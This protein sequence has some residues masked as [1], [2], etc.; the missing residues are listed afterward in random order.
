[1]YLD[2]HY[3]RTYSLPRQSKAQPQPV[4]KERIKIQPLVLTSSLPTPPSSPRRSPSKAKPLDLESLSLNLLHLIHSSTS[5]LTDIAALIHPECQIE[6]EFSFRDNLHF[7]N[8][9]DDFLVHLTQR[10]TDLARMKL[11]VRESAVDEGQKKVWVVADVSDG[12][13]QTKT[14]KEKVVMMTFDAE[15]KLTK[16]VAFI[17]RVSTRGED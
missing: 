4:L 7:Y 6:H 5:S 2:N 16:M 3:L 15:G 17:R 12:K 10:R 8:S 1:M 13:E 9:R 14:S 11:D